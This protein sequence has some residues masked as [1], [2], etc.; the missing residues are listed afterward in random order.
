MCGLGGEGEDYL[1]NFKTYKLQVFVI[2]LLEA[3]D[4]PK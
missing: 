1:C 4:L 3:L 2:N